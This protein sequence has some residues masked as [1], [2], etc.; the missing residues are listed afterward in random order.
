M[1]DS[2]NDVDLQ[3]AIALSLEENSPPMR[4]LKPATV[5][6]LTVSDDEY[7]DDL[8]APVTARQ[9]ASALGKDLKNIINPQGG[10]QIVSE[11]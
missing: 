5:I 7:D 6:D 9:H 3:R 11:I 1:A 4:K 2:D 10:L 8:D